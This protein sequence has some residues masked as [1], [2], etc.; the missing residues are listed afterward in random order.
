MRAFIALEEVKLRDA[1]SVISAHEEMPTKNFCAKKF[2]R[3]NFL[4]TIA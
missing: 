2:T 1:M 3:N 4:L